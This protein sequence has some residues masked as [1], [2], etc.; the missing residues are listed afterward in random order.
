[1]S[2]VTAA[3]LAITPGVDLNHLLL[4]QL[5]KFTKR[6]TRQVRYYIREGAIDPPIGR[7]ASAHYTKN[8]VDQVEATKR[9]LDAGFTLREFAA[10]RKA[11]GG[12]KGGPVPLIEVGAESGRSSSATR[13]FR[14]TGNI[15]ILTASPLSPAEYGIFERIRK[16]AALSSKEKQALFKKVSR[17]M[18]AQKARA[19]V[20]ANGRPAFDA[21]VRRTVED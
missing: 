13:L 7:T 3:M 10:T 2:K 6:T 14:V 1:M 16:A 11:A 8:H 12:K 5:C 15:Y 17:T 9:A 18:P 4:P 19:A 21:Q 20:H